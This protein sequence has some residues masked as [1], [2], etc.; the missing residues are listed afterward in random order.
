MASTFAAASTADT[1][2][3]SSSGW[4]T[5]TGTMPKFVANTRHSSL[6][7]AIPAGK[8]MTIPTSVTPVACQQTAA[9]TWRRTNPSTFSNPVSRRRLATLTSSRCTIV[10]A[11]NIDMATPNSSGKFTDSPKLTSEKPAFPAGT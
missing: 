6:P 3:A 4:T 2:A 9:A 10:A 11:P 5:G 1:S 7:A 8:P